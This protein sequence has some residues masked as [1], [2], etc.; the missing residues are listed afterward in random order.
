MIISPNLISLLI[1]PSDG[2][3]SHVLLQRLHQHR[4]GLQLSRLPV[5][6]KLLHQENTWEHVQLQLPDRQQGQQGIVRHPGTGMHGRFLCVISFVGP[7]LRRSIT[8][9]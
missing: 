9:L 1:R 2:I 4:A 7:G 6:H 8:H 5:A 3:A